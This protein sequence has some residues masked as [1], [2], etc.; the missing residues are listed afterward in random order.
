MICEVEAIFDEVGGRASLETGNTKVEEP[1]P[2]DVNATWRAA[3]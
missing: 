1:P 3:L 2:G